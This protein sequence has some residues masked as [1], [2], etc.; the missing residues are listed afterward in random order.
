MNTAFIF[1]KG[2][3]A[4]GVRKLPYLTAFL[5]ELAVTKDKAKAEC[6]VDW[7]LLP[8]NK[9]ARD[10]AAKHH[11]PFIALE[12]GFLRSLGLGVEG[13]PPYSVVFDDTG[14][15]YDTTRPSRLEQLILNADTMPSEILDDAEKAIKLILDNK[16]SKYNHAPEYPANPNPRRPSEK[17]TVLVIDQTAGDMAVKYGSADENTFKHMF[18]TALSENPDAEIWVKTH[19]DVLSGKKRGYLTDI[20]LQTGN[21]RVL[22]E[23]IN[24]ISL[25]EQADKVYC[26]T[27]QMGFEAMMME[28]PV[29]TFG[30]PWYAGW[31]ISDDR[32][33]AVHEL[34]AQ[35]RRANRNMIRLFAA[36]YLQYSR[37]VN[38][39]TGDT[40]TLFDVIDYLASA[41]RLN[42]KLRGNLYCLGMTFWKRAVVKPFLNVPSCRPHFISSF[43]KL[44]SLTL[45]ADAKILAWGADNEDVTAFARQHNLP[46]LRMEDGFVR[47]VGLG[48]NLVPP[49]SLVT[50][51]MGIYFNPNTLSR[52]EHILQNQTFS[53][54]DFQTASYLQRVLTESKISKYNVGKGR[55]NIPDTSRKVLLV[56]G[57][58]EDDASI[59]Y[60]SP[61][62]RTNLGL[63]KKVRGL[64]PDAYIIYKPH[65]DVVSGNRVG[66]IPPEEASRYADQTVT[67]CDIITC[68]KYAGEVH[69]MTSLSGFEALL[70]GKAVHCYG[71]PFYAGWGLTHDYL[72]LP[73]RT[74]KLAL[75]EL[76]A[77]TLI[78]YPDYIN[79][80]TKY[81]TDVTTAINILTKQKTKLQHSDLL[82]QHI[83]S[84]QWG[85]LKQIYSLLK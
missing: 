48:S 29:V 66:A 33:P 4:Q 20:S 85:K 81:R 72:N 82:P 79:P 65:P 74:R 83:I 42:E 73:R 15:Y 44:K 18:Q 35:N 49:L 31:G 19:P 32:H 2:I 69:T 68:L 34:Y 37:Y 50:D 23:D 67:E 77:G 46:L 52:L 43:G 63:L 70:R 27:S 54:K 78:H 22:A 59:R 75:W 12:D 26:V 40:G 14:I 36:A 30:L 28:K 45:P 60:G 5:P 38:P 58:V 56:P 39:N 24:P 7:G 11:L 6:I 62:I 3:R 80:E 1:T 47:S 51:D 41:R 53:Q 16:L 13:W 64:N 84:K 71:L 25:L 57:Q 21:V 61:E 55:L 10:Y 9:K 17:K 76:I 8:T